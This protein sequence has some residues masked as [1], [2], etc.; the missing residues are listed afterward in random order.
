MRWIHEGTPK[1]HKFEC[2][3]CHY[4]VYYP[5]NTYQPDT[6][7]QNPYPRC[8]WCGKEIEAGEAVQAA[9]R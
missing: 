9:R 1:G 2:P 4:P 5:Q 7:P 6:G 8:P 3:F